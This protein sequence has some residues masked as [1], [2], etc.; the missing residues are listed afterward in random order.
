MRNIINILI[1]LPVIAFSQ[2][3]GFKY[4]AVI[5]DASGDLLYNQQVSIKTTILSG[6]AIGT[7]EYAETHLVGTNGYGVVNLNIG[8]GTIVSGSYSNIDWSSA[9]HFLKTELDIT[10]GNNFQFMGT[11]QILSVPLASHAQTAATALDDNDRNATNEIQQ[12]SIN[13]DTIKLSSGGEVYLGSYLDNTDQQT[14][15]L[16]GNQLLISGGNAVTLSGTLDLDP[17]PT[18]E[19][20][21]LSLSN[22]TLYLS[23]GNYVVLQPDADGDA[24]NELQTLSIANNDISI[25]NG[26]TISL[27]LSPVNNDND[28][29]NELQSLTL[30]NNTLSITNGN[31]VTLPPDGDSDATNEIQTLNLSNNS[32][33]ISGSNSV[34]LP[35]NNDNSSTNELQNLTLSN[36]T[37]SISN[38]NSVNLPANNDNSSTNELQTLTY[39]NDTLSI[40]NGNQI[41]LS[42]SSLDLVFPDGRD[43]INSISFAQ[44]DTS[45]QLIAVP[46]S[47]W[48]A[49]SQFYSTEYIVPHGKNLIITDYVTSHPQCQTHQI[50]WG[51]QLLINSTKMF[52]GFSAANVGYTGLESPTFSQPLMLGAGDTLKIIPPNN[53]YNSYIGASW[54]RGYLVNQSVTPITLSSSGGSQYYTVPNNKTLVILNV[55]GSGN[56]L[57]YN[58]YNGQRIKYGRINYFNSSSS[59]DESVMHY[60]SLS[61]PIILN[62]GEIL[63][64]SFEGVNGY[65]MDK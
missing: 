10:G 41:V 45:F 34:T 8:S 38:G 3:T 22:D 26:N 39:Q 51:C 59:I 21:V 33:S 18:N 24:T 16:Q 57:Q 29:T 42:T 50:N 19:L 58:D 14:L 52:I 40:S 12:L 64:Y 27:P 17:D 11:S 9:S 5:R 6:S 25:S 2:L 47:S 62:E 37:L 23:N 36:N 35:T 54:A 53:C 60:K 61:K 65:L 32:L 20:Q 30:N 15:S 63:Y 7:E 46:Q 49:L 31:S 43:N 55:C 48:S 13:A 44:G 28:S 4:Q 1:F 56:T